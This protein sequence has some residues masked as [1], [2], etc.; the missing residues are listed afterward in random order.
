MALEHIVESLVLLIKRQHEELELYRKLLND[1]AKPNKN[2]QESNECAS[3]DIEV[4]NGY[5]DYE[6][7][8]EEM[9]VEEFDLDKFVN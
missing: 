1:S 4:N 3:M 5:N 9:Y 7:Y 2:I 6:M 8:D